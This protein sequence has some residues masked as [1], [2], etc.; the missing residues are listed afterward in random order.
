MIAT[1]DQER[2]ALEQIR[3]IVADLGEDSYIGTAFE[4][5]FEIAEQNIENDS[6]ISFKDIVED[7]K[8]RAR[9][10]GLDNRDLRN[11]VSNLKQQI[12]DMEE[13]VRETERKTIPE[14]DKELIMSVMYAR[15]K[16]V[17]DAVCENANSIVELAE[18]PDTPEFREAVET[19]RSNK[20]LLDRFN[21]TIAKLNG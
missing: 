17:E 8:E 3:K 12:A 10:L 21:E 19:H 4:G 1:K 15:K 14:K 5:C 20:R 11:V 18:D 6:A 13:K 2:K 16:V 7:E 9:R